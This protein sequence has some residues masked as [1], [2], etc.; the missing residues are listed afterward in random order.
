[1][2]SFQRSPFRVVASGLKYPEGPVVLKDGSLVV[3]EIGAG[4]LTR[5]DVATGEKSTLANLGGGPNGLA[6]GPDGFLYVANNGGVYI[7][8]IGGVDVVVMQS[9]T[10]SGGVL[11]KVDSST[12]KTETLYTSFQAV[13]PLTQQEQTYPLKSPDDLVFDSTGNIWFTDWGQTRL[14]TRVRD[15]T[16][17]Y[18]AK[19]DGSSIVEA[20]SGMQAPNGIAL[21]PDG[22]RLYVAETYSRMILYW[23]LSAPGVIQ[24]NPATVDGSYLLTAHPPGQGG[25]DSMKVDS[26]GNVYVAT[27]LVDGLNPKSN[28]GIS[29]F[30]AEGQL[31]EYIEINADD[32]FDP[33]PSNLCF[34]GPD[35]TTG[36]FTLG[37]TGRV[38]SCEMAIPGLAPAWSKQ[39]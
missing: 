23:E 34:A 31:L 7:Q 36:Y 9:P 1:M 17:V 33:L 39:G 2:S 29:I 32:Q 37:G 11:Q 20:V 3:C 16:G 4:T 15:I 24:H 5:I 21:S 13:N 28:G 27:I 14:D 12:G 18:Y 10:Y 35:L 25:L 22:S 19:A 26:E 8:N 30:S 6:L 38:V